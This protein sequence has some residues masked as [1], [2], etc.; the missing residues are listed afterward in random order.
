MRTLGLVVISLL[1]SYVFIAYLSGE[2]KPFHWKIESQAWALV[3][4]LTFLVLF[5][6]F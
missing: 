6:L 4:E 2:W 1:V 5:L 3:G